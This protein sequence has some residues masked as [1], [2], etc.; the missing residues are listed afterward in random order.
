MGNSASGSGFLAKKFFFVYE[1]LISKSAKRGVKLEKREA[2]CHLVP[3][4]TIL[5]H[6]VWY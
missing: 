1:P 4:D 5:C 2:P 6:L 3:L